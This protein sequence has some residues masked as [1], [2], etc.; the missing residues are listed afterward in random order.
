MSSAL[1]TGTATGIG[2][3]VALTLAKRGWHLTLL[4]ID[5]AGLE[6]T[7][8]DARAAAAAAGQAITVTTAVVDVTDAAAQERAFAGHVARHGSLTLA[9]LNAGIGERGDVFDPANGA[10]QRTM[11]I[12]LT[13]VIAGVRAA[14]LAMGPTGGG[15]VVAI[16]SA[17]GFFP[18]PVAPVYA[19]AK[20]GVVHFVRSAARGLASKAK[21]ALHAVCPEFVDTPLVRSVQASNPAHA[22]ALLGGDNV[23]LLAPATVAD[24]V[25]QVGLTPQKYKPGTVALLRQDGSVEFPSVRALMGGKGQPG[26]G[27]APG[28]KGGQGGQSKQAAGVA[29]GSAEVDSVTRAAR[30]AWATSG[31]RAAGKKVQVHTLSSD[32]DAATCVVDAPAPALPTPPGTLLLRVVYAGVNA[33]DVNYSAGRYH[34]S[35]AEA[36]AALPYDAGFEA[37]GVVADVGQGVAGWQLGDCAAVLSYGAFADYT[38]VKAAS[39]LRVP[40]PTPQAVALLT[41]GLTASIALSEAGSLKRGETVLVTAAAGGTGQFAV[42]L[43]KTA[44]CHVIATAGGP[45]KCDLVQSLGADRVI[46][47]KRESLKEVLKKEYPHGVDVVYEGV[48]GDMFTAS[49]NALAP[50]GRLIIIGMM[51][52]YKDGWPVTALPPGL[53]EKLLWK[54]ASLTGFFLLRYAPLFKS[55]FARLLALAGS[56]QLAVAVDPAQ[57]VGVGAAGRA[58]AHLHSGA[59]MGKVVLQVAR[60]LPPGLPVPHRGAPASRL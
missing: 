13:A 18:M 51:S 23:P 16:A 27:A 29:G 4:D 49:L 54:S 21:V 31:L 26:A 48:G 36:R 45:A 3:E 50:R 32:F 20:A 35:Q 7:A 56:G 30:A 59:S 44:G 58:V 42:Q 22:R 47:Y 15:S 39:A 24:L 43:A 6:Q 53:P 60:E 17:G 52:S 12:D 57:F 38:V 33:S 28:S 40:H 14:A 25:L 11:D 5:A 41:S 34:N 10:W 37:V 1:I 8:K 46:D 2:R 9:V 55:H 19:A